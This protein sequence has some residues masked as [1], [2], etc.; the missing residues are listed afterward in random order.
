MAEKDEIK[1]PKSFQDE[2][3][4]NFRTLM[5]TIENWQGGKNLSEEQ[6]ARLK[7][8]LPG[9]A[10]SLSAIKEILGKKGSEDSEGQVKPEVQG[11]KSLSD[12]DVVRKKRAGGKKGGG[13][14]YASQNKKYGGGVYPRKTVGSDD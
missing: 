12:A 9:S 3:P 11:G 14:V 7:E 4:K 1:E 8:I 13:K 6:I 2:E 10:I 5:A